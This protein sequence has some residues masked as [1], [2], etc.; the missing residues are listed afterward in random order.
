MT[1]DALE[2]VNAWT[3]K[4]DSAFAAAKKLEGSFLNKDKDFTD[5][6]KNLKEQYEKA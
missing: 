2:L 6:L 3:I 1:T 5:R 4:L